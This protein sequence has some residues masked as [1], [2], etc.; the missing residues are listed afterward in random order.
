MWFFVSSCTKGIMLGFFK[1]KQ[2]RSGSFLIGGVEYQ[3]FKELSNTPNLIDHFVS[4]C[5]GL[6]Q[7]PFNLKD[8]VQKMVGLAQ[9][10]IS[11]TGLGVNDLVKSAKS[12][13]WTSVEQRLNHA[14]DTLAPILE[15]ARPVLNRLRTWADAHNLPSL[16]PFDS[17]AYQMTG[18]PREITA[19]F[20][21][22]QLHLPN[23]GLKTLPEELAYLPALESICVDGNNLKALPSSIFGLYSLR[24][25]DAEGN[26]IEEIPDSIG[27]AQ[28]LQ[29]L[30]LDGNNLTSVSPEIARCSSLKR[31]YF[32]DQRHGTRLDH[33]DT[34]LSDDAM[35]ALASLDARS[36]DIRF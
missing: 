9:S 27:G 15:K 24:R 19:I 30:D 31:A 8:D 2:N 33:R 14:S 23:A 25:I 10:L 11:V 3:Q 16:A 35:E 20:T 21:L 34:P 29:S 6:S 32:R 13:N 28:H 18:F 36:V 22:R 1:K 4:V 17:S 26:E 5:A 12:N 7:V